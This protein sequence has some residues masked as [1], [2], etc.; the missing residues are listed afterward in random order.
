MSARRR[1]GAASSTKAAGARPRWAGAAPAGLS[2]EWTTALEAFGAHLSTSTRSPDTVATYVRHVQWLAAAV[3]SGP[4]ALRSA[5]L[6][7]WLAGQ[8]WSQQTRRK[9]LVSVNHFYA[10]GVAESYVRW[11]PTAGVAA[12]PPRTP[13]PPP[14]G[15]PEPWREPVE[16]Y[17]AHLRAGGLSTATMEQYLHR[18]RQLAQLS[19]SPW[20]VT[21]L[22][23]EL[24]LANPSWGAETRRAS[25]VAARSFFGWAEKA[26]HVPAS[27]AADLARVHVPRRLPR[28]APEDAVQAALWD[29]DDR[30][31]LAIMLARYAGL[32][33][34]EIARLHMD[35]VTDTY[36]LVD[37]KGGKQR[38][39]PLD[40]EGDLAEA[41]RVER[42]RRR[43]GRHGTGWHG[44]YVSARGY[45]FPSVY[46]PGPMTAARVGEIIAEGL[47]N[48]PLTAHPLRHRFATNA[49]AAERDLQAV[50]QL[51]GH[52]RP[53]TTAIYAQ[54]P[55]GALLAAVRGAGPTPLR[56]PASR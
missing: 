6:A 51:L 9:V 45:V 46:H 32:R 53:E 40:P 21:T 28:P 16:Q 55:D 34:A 19:T 18:V 4:W 24:W 10:W 3:E 49:Y 17:T 44:R 39:V 30:T 13:G 38:I 42:A 11:S 50:Q 52:A 56:P 7:G 29:A 22:Q 48:N 33:R 15:W 14:S 2:A 43:E 8:Q 12:E 54:V 35:Q 47:G 20:E 23:L 26:K 1:H 27:P 41:L 37:G 5:E 36:L 25:G 31:R